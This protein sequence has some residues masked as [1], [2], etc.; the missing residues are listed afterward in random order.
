MAEKNPK[1]GKMCKHTDL[2]ES[3]PGY[4]KGRLLKT[5]YKEKTLRAT[6][7]TD[8]IPIKESQFEY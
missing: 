7:N 2:K 4:I 1:S 5:K 8:A 6:K 3:T